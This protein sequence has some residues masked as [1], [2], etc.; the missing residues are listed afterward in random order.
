MYICTT[1]L[2]QSPGKMA[3]G[4]LLIRYDVQILWACM[5]RKKL[6]PPNIQSLVSIIKY[7]N[8]KNMRRLYP[9]LVNPGFSVVLS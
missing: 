7:T 1:K 9:N 5:E 3:Q 8:S 4:G 6:T 2:E